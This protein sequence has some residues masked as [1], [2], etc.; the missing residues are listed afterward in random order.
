MTVT[1]IGGIMETLGN[2]M[3]TFKIMENM[4]SIF[5]QVNGNNLLKILGALMLPTMG[6]EMWVIYSPKLAPFKA[7]VKL[8]WIFEA[9]RA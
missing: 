7:Q 2:I 8:K 9:A 5:I 3:D 6:M 1:A 4:L